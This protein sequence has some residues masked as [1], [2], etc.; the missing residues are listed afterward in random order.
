MCSLC[1]GMPGLTGSQ[2]ALHTPCTRA[3]PLLRLLLV[4]YMSACGLHAA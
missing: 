3:L 2:K 1:L 4:V